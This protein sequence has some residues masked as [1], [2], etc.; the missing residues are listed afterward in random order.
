M[1]SAV[2]QENL[3]LNTSCGDTGEA[4]TPGTCQQ[5]RCR[6]THGS[7]PD[8]PSS[9]NHWDQV[10]SRWPEH[11]SEGESSRPI[12][13]A[14]FE[15]IDWY[16]IHLG[17]EI[18]AHVQCAHCVDDVL[19]LAAFLD[20]SGVRC[21][22]GEAV[23]LLLRTLK[24]LRLCDYWTEDICSILAHASVYFSNVSLL[25]GDQMDG[26]EVGNVLATLIFIAHCYVQDETCPLQIWHQC[27]F[28]KYCPLKTL[29]SAVVRLM[30]I[31]NFILRL[32][33]TVLNPR[34]NRLLV[35]IQHHS[36]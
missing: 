31:L 24:F 11:S 4:M 34:Y 29:N 6:S 3:A 36:C 19:L 2:Q 14:S 23:R 7:R 5:L 20:L 15:T 8:S 9:T 22:R 17:E 10:A 33:N 25:C 26:Q 28:V 18:R 27:L 13:N 32:E 35:T 16:T 1:S 30:E 12:A 21:I